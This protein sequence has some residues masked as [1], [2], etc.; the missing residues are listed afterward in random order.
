M[1][2]P[3]ELLTMGA[4]GILSGVM[5]MWSQHLKAKAQ[6]HLA[7]IEKASL[8]NEIFSRAREFKGSKSYQFT[9]RIIAL[10]IVGA[11]VILPKLLPLI[12]IDVTVGWTEVV[13]GFW[14]WSDD[15]TVIKWHTVQGLALTPWDNHLVASVIGFYFGNSVVKNV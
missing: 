11:V 5:T 9:R 6:A 7:L 14:W 12:G 15:T 8:Q 10:S 3:L 4:S 1:S 13:S 2:I